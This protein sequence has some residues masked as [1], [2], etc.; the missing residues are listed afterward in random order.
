MR[1]T[2]IDALP[3]WNAIRIPSIVVTMKP[4]L[5]A[6]MN[7]R[8]GREGLAGVDVDPHRCHW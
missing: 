7:H 8:K 3:I 6:S 4:K 2:A 5:I 1:M